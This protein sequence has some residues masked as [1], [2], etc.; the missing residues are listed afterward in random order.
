MWKFLWKFQY[1]VQNI[2]FSPLVLVVALLVCIFESGN[3]FDL[4]DEYF[5]NL[6]RGYKT[7][8]EEVD[9]HSEKL[10]TLETVG[11]AFVSVVL[12]YIVVSML[13]IVG[14]VIVKS[15]FM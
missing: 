11:F 8:N 3:L 6:S 10:N 1:T 12:T 5:G 4:M 13:G 9:K 15:C 7:I 14:G 2:L